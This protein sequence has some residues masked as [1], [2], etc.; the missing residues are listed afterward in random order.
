MSPAFREATCATAAQ[1]DESGFHLLS[2]GVSRKMLSPPGAACRVGRLACLPCLSRRLRASLCRERIAALSPA[3]QAAGQ[4]PN[5]RDP[6]PAK[7]Q[8][9]PGAGRLVGSTAVEH[10]LAVG[11]NL[12]LPRLEL[13]RLQMVGPGNGLRFGLEVERMAQV[14][15]HYLFA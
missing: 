6:S 9:H 11:G 2:F 14:H 13:R 12:T 8:R 4:R 5:A 3:F 15:D 7:Q 1:S 10:D